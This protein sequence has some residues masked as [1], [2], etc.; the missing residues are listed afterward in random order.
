MRGNWT[1]T[2]GHEQ[3]ETTTGSMLLNDS[4]VR[5]IKTVDLAGNGFQSWISHA[6]NKK[7]RKKITHQIIKTDCSSSAVRSQTSDSREQMQIRNYGWS[8]RKF[9]CVPSQ[10]QCF[11]RGSCNS[12]MTSYIQ[13]LHLHHAPLALCY[14]DTVKRKERKRLWVLAELVKLYCIVFIFSVRCAVSIP[15]VLNH[16]GLCPPTQPPH[17]ERT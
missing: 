4:S 10:L 13:L 3:Q 1:R 16:H 15:H 12:V 7:K 2:C 6:N 8:P 17:F 11:D 14:T 9:T 5:S